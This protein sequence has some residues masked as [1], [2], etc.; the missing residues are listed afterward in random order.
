MKKAKQS[1]STNKSKEAESETK[2]K[3]VE[4]IAAELHTLPGVQVERNK[5]LPSLINPEDEREIDVLL[6]VNPVGYE[7]RIAIECKNLSRRIEAKDIGEFADKL[8]Q[9]GVPTQGS[10]YVS[11]SKYRRGAYTRAKELGIILLRPTGL[12]ADRLAIIVEEAFQS[13]VFLLA[14]A[15]E[16]TIRNDV[17]SDVF[18][19]VPVEDQ[20]AIYDKNGKLFGMMPDLIWEKWRY[21]GIPPSTIGEHF[22]EV[23]IPSG[24]HQLIQGKQVPILRATAKVTVWGYVVSIS[25]KLE[26]ISL[27]DAMSESPVKIK[28]KA[29]FDTSKKR[30]PVTTFTTEEDF[31]SFIKQ[32]RVLHIFSNRIR[33]PRILTQLGFWP[34]SKRAALKLVNLMMAFERGEIPDPRPIDYAQIEG[35]DLSAVWEEVIEGSPVIQRNIDKKPFDE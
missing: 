24:W 4:S 19:K 8:R 29:L 33:L 10:V 5:W 22:V 1:R 3:L 11:A 18:S 23:D 34:P 12:T 31:Q 17:P 13:I 32:P 7:M 14:V 25:G 9:V 16:W 20:H 35:N 6:T 2:K 26:R 21:D 30:Y 28:V 15:A 27:L